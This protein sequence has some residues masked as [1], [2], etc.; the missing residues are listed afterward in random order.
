MFFKKAET[1]G[2][3]AGFAIVVGSLAVVGVMSITK[4]GNKMIRSMCKKVTD[5]FNQGKTICC[6][7]NSE[8]Q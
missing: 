5:L 4:C 3:G 6:Q 2:H 1:K 7:E 8:S